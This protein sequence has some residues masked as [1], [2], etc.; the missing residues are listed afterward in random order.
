MCWMF[1]GD[2]GSDIKPSSSSSSSSFSRFFLCCYYCFSFLLPPLLSCF[3]LFCLLLLLLLPLPLP[4]LIVVFVWPLRPNRSMRLS[5][6]WQHPPHPTT[7]KQTH[8]HRTSCHV[9]HLHIT[10]TLKPGV[11]F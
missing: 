2:T 7:C 10:V 9:V 11:P 4:S 3:S 8:M 5:H 1:I 6:L